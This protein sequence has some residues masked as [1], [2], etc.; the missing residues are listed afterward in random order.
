MRVPA[1][2]LHGALVGPPHVVFVLL[3]EVADPELGAE[4]IVHQVHQVL[5]V[6][7]EPN[8]KIRALHVLM[9]VSLTVDVFKAVKDLKS[10]VAGRL[11]GEPA[12]LR[13]VNDPL[14][15]R[16]KPLHHQESVHLPVL[17]MGPVRNQ[18][19]YS[20]MLEA[21]FCFELVHFLSFCCP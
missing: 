2:V 5:A 20:Q 8:K 10:D 3:V 13:V 9:D 1:G 15:V 12:A 17:L 18:L 4:A 16:P 14:E 19:G 21:F 6:Q 11:G 7:A